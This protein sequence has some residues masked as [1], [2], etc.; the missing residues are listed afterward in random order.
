MNDTLRYVVFAFVPEEKEP[1]RVGTVEAFSY[2]HAM[3][4]ARECYSYL[5]SAGRLRLAGV[6]KEK[7]S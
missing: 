5:W 4:E 3:Q 2:D 7:K 1:V 6:Q